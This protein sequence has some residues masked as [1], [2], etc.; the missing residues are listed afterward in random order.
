MD[1]G[2]IGDHRPVEDVIFSPRRQLF[3]VEHD[4]I[5]GLQGLDVVAFFRAVV[6]DQ[7]EIIRDF[8]LQ[9]FGAVGQVVRD[10]SERA[11]EAGRQL[12]VCPEI[13][14]PEIARIGSRKVFVEFHLAAG[15]EKQHL[16]EETFIPLHMVGLVQRGENADVAVPVGEQVAGGE[17]AALIIVRIDGDVAAD[18]AENVDNGA[19]R[20]GGTN[21]LQ[22]R[23]GRKRTH[24]DDSR[25]GNGVEE[26]L[27]LFGVIAQYAAEIA[28]GEA[29][30]QQDSDPLDE[31]AADDVE[32]DGL[33]LLLPRTQITVA[34]EGR[35]HL[36]PGGGADRSL[37]VHHPVESP[38]T[39]SGFVG[40]IVK[41][42][43]VHDSLPFCICL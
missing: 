33:R 41:V 10:S 14:H 29:L 6:A 28:Q 43:S 19:V 1:T 34:V 22:Q 20:I 25:L 24:H 12:L 21:L 16:A 26:A 23:F 3:D 18:S 39:D 7:A 30:H 5:E 37:I 17:L 38:D 9:L 40:D 4:R 35:H 8:Q 36:A 32:Q 15:I 11:E 27:L 2:L 13:I 31:G 42:N